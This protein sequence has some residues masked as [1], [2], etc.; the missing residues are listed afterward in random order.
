[1]DDANFMDERQLK[2]TVSSLSPLT[3]KF[4][5]ELIEAL[6][7]RFP[8]YKT[9]EA[10]CL[11]YLDLLEPPRCRFCDNFAKF[12]VL[13]K[14]VTKA[15]IA[16]WNDVCS[17]QCSLNKN[18]ET[19]LKKYGTIHHLSKG[20]SS[21]SMEKQKNTNIDRYGTDV[22]VNSM[23]KEIQERIRERNNG[24][25]YM[26]K[27]SNS[28]IREKIMKTNVTQRNVL[29]A[30]Q[31]EEVKE[32]IK[33]TNLER[34]GVEYP[35]QNKEIRQ[36][37]ID[38][39]IEKYGV[40]N[41]FAAQSV[42]EKCNRTYHE[43]L[44][45]TH[46]NEKARRFYTNL[47]EFGEEFAILLEIDDIVQPDK[48]IRIVDLSN[49]TGLPGSL[50][51]S[52]ASEYESIAIRIDNTS[53]SWSSST[54]RSLAN[55]IEFNGINVIR[56]DRST[57]G[58]KELDILI[59]EHNVAIEVNGV[60]YHSEHRGGKGRT[61]HL[62]KTIACHNKEIRL[63]HFTDIE[64]DNKIDIIR[65]MILNAC[66]RT[67]HKIYARKCVVHDVPE[68]HA[69]VFFQENH[70][71]GNARFD[72]AY[73]LYLNGELVMCMSIGASRNGHREAEYEIIR[74]ATKLNHIVVGGFTKI[75]SHFIN[76]KDPESVLSYQE[77]KY[78]GKPSNSYASVMKRE[79]D[80]E[81]SWE[82]VHIKKGETFHRLW[83][84][85]NRMQDEFE[86]YQED[87]TI[88]E[89]MIENGLDRIWNC[90]Q[91]VWVYRK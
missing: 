71:Q 50:I 73:G 48:C 30:F 49:V 27:R 87:K 23:T 75:W 80:T 57:I 65:S 52:I 85:K 10:A 20:S 34:H 40:P 90:G 17:H 32:K 14:A 89:N 18:K 45:K 24:Y 46:P 6:K 38:A 64:L 3:T 37:A 33:I 55:W 5:K 1:M 2:E 79:K 4:K 72:F 36:K 11:L 51:H 67:E 69:R 77:K 47:L 70:I 56:G 21:R 74:V 29:H 41:P 8:G 28:G 54:E 7:E 13:G 35:S 66:G 88:F 25:H 60:Y 68:E 76:D 44:S 61:Y 62:E 91:F 53:S 26:D 12:V 59:P 86:N 31:C 16:G 39:W 63:F 82:G 19:C 9:K 78:G 42:I 81:P 58:P 84:T 15:H 43:N 22:A 83:F